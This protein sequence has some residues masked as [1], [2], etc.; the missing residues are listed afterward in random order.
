VLL[1]ATRCYLIQML[2]WA[3]TCTNGCSCWSAGE[4]NSPQFFPYHGCALPTELGGRVSVLQLDA[5]I[6]AV[7]LMKATCTSETHQHTA[8][9]MIPDRCCIGP[10]NG[11]L[12][13]YPC[14]VPPPTLQEPHAAGLRI[15]RASTV[16]RCIDGRYT[17]AGQARA[18]VGW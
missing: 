5:D 17:N 8:P 13:S 4:E 11:F 1:A 16:R 12:I 7:M 15:G 18:P 2:R 9:M 3:L 10:A 6:V 14:V